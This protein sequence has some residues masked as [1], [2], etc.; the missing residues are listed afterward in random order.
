M[1]NLLTEPFNVLLVDTRR[2]N[3]RAGSVSFSLSE[4]S[5]IDV[6]AA[7]AC[8]KSFGKGDGVRDDDKP[9]DDID[10]FDNGDLLAI[11]FSMWNLFSSI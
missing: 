9:I 4:D 7:I 3:I 10:G 2:W 6:A 5:S 11:I 8:N 1:L